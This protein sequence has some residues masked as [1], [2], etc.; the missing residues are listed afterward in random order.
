[1]AF[2][3]SGQ[4]LDPL[5]APV[6]ESL[7]WDVRD[8]VRAIPEHHANAPLVADLEERIHAEYIRRDQETP[9]VAG[10]RVGLEAVEALLKRSMRDHEELTPR[11]LTLLP[12][13]ESELLLS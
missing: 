7:F 2:T 11:G 8:W 12:K 5:A 6:L 4:P 1:L 13:Y 9:L 10:E 3:Q